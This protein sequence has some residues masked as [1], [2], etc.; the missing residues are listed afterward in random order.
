ME[1]IEKRS[2]IILFIIS[3]ILFMLIPTVGYSEQYEVTFVWE[4]SGRGMEKFAFSP[5]RTNGGP[6]IG[7]HDILISDLT[8]S[9]VDGNTR[10]TG[11][12]TVDVEDRNDIAWW[13]CYAETSYG[14]QSAKSEPAESSF[15]PI[16]P[17]ALKR[18][19]LIDK[20]KVLVSF[21]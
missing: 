8:S 21:I 20:R 18:I 9:E 6:W 1:T 10:W 19:M 16:S 2:C 17:K 14:T 12:I 15:A 11:K 5:A 3:F 13:I 4:H 7:S